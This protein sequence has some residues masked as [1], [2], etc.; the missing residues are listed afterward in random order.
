MKAEKASRENII[1]YYHRTEW[2]Y[3]NYWEL[4]KSMGLH[5]GFWDDTVK[6]HAESI[7]RQNACMAEMAGIQATDKV[8]DAGCG[9]GELPPMGTGNSVWVIG[10]YERIF[11]PT[12]IYVAPSLQACVFATPA[13]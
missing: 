13:T 12:C 5:Y 2:V 4:D 11:S 1:Q 6:T 8:L 10:T 9:V 3:R 7:V